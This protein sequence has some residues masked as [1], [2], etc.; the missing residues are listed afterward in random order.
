MFIYTTNEEQTSVS[1][2]HTI[3]GV[4]PGNETYQSVGFESGSNYKNAPFKE[5]S[6]ST[7][8]AYRRVTATSAEITCESSGSNYG[9]FFGGVEH[10]CIAMA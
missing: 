7:S 9:C 2:I 3:I 8:Y 6:D 5:S 4:F 1:N 10:I